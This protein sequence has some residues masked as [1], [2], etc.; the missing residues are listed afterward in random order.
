[1]RNKIKTIFITNF[2]S[3]VSKNIL[4]SDI[5]KILSVQKNLRI[6]ILAPDY[7]KDFLKKYYASRKVVIESINPKLII[8]S[9]IN[10][11]FSRIAFL[12]IDSHYLWYKKKERLIRSKSLRAYLKYFFEICFTK[13]FSNLKIINKVFRF[14]DFNFAPKKFFKK[15]F[16]KYQPCC[17]FATDIF[18]DTDAAIL[19]ES[20]ANKVF[21]IGMV[22]SWDNGYS[23]GLLRVLP[24]KVIVNNKIIKKEMQTLHNVR[25]KDMTVVGLPQ[26]DNYFCEGRVTRKD[27]FK[28]LGVNQGKKLI[29]FAPAGSILSNTDWQIC[30]ILKNALSKGFLPSN[31]HFLVRNHPGHPASLKKFVSDNNF[32]IEI[33][34]ARFEEASVKNTELTPKDI[35][36]L[37]DSLY[38][39]EVIVYV[40]TSI[41]IDAAV[42]NKP[43]I[44]ISFDGWEKKPYIESV[45]R[46]HNEDH[47]KKLINTGGVRVVKSANELI[48]W[49]NQYL[50]NP[51]TDE[52]GRK[53]I[54]KEQ[55]WKFD[56]RAGERI[57]KFILN[58]I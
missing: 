18:S 12:L 53:K 36:H 19:R 26:F 54:I 2:H 48:Y 16:E 23:K 49:I 7:K 3:F 27:F 4:D 10:I 29:L 31:I 55:F 37:A 47:M 58:Q 41:G 28:S 56:G 6:V 40:A 42:F 17:V 24:D 46:Y 9:K 25:T 13:L 14:L 1:M 44:M 21:T 51:K 33:P 39:S 34:G 35:Q 57:A 20:K 22:R 8:G 52:E 50:Q 32:T 38:H 5:L 45:K 30:Q 11:L 15:Y 43:Q